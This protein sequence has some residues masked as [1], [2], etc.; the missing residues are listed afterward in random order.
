M[1]NTMRL[2]KQSA[3]ALIAGN[4]AFALSLPVWAAN[5]SADFTMNGTPVTTSSVDLETGV[6]TALKYTGGSN[7]CT[8][9]E[10]FFR[11]EGQPDWENFAHVQTATLEKLWRAGTH[12][13]KMTATG[14]NGKWFFGLFGCDHTGQ[15]DER[16]VNINIATSGFAQTKYPIMLVPGVMAF[17]N[18]L[19]MEYFFRVADKIRESSDQTVVDVSLAAWQNTEDRGADLANKIIDVLLETDPDF[20]L[21]PTMKVNLIAH[22]HGSTTSRMAINILARHFQNQNENKPGKVASLTTVSGPHYGTPTADGTHWAMENWGF[23]GKLLGDFLI[24]SLIGNIG[25]A[26]VAILSGHANE[27]PEQDIKHVLRDFTQKG[28]ARFNTCYPSAGLPQGGKY[29]IEPP[30]DGVEESISLPIVDGQVTV[31]DCQGYLNANANNNNNNNNNNDDN[32]LPPFFVPGT[33]FSAQA[34]ITL[35]ETPNDAYGA[36]TETLIGPVYG[37]GLGDETVPTDPN[38]VRY[39]SFTG[40]GEWNT[41]FN[42]EGLAAN[43]QD[44]T[45]PALLVIQSMFTIVGERTDES[46][47]GQWLAEL[48]EDFTTGSDPTLRN[49]GYT[50]ESDAFIPVDSTRFGEFIGSFGPWNHL[51]EMNAFLGSIPAN[52]DQPLTVYEDHVNRLQQGGL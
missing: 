44:Y 5:G 1:E 21:N 52:A 35:A 4:L 41:M 40:I 6:P 12:E 2:L 49:R 38:A 29:F 8:D 9:V 48:V 36:G 26:A 25:G 23:T 47:F 37:N 24:E 20:Y 3:K 27:Y 42:K 50:G 39:F 15:Y 7:T 14:F 32:I 10:W 19:G 22:S 43:E 31:T 45:D 13:L 33:H 34:P 28:M 18:I 11:K 16:T 46:F 30:L 51:D 17:D